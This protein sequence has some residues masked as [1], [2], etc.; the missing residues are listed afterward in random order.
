MAVLIF[1]ADQPVAPSQAVVALA[2]ALP[3]LVPGAILA[4]IVARV[5]A[6]YARRWQPRGDE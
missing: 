2:I 4:F 1:L 6:W 5:S 3:I